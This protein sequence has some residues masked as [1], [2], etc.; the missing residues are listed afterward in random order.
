MR[1]AACASFGYR[2]GPFGYRKPAG[3]R[4]SMAISNTFGTLPRPMLPAILSAEL[5]K[6]A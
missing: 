1:R 3:P 6:A 4:P 2:P 5:K